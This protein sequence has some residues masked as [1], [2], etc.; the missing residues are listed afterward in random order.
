MHT[1]HSSGVTFKY[2]TGTVSDLPDL[3]RPEQVFNFQLL[4]II[5]FWMCSDPDNLQ[6]L[7]LSG[8]EKMNHVNVSV[9]AGLRLRNV[10]VWLYLFHIKG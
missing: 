3:Y 1:I 5:P 9:S 4:L 8:K 2:H 6:N 10:Q 7:S